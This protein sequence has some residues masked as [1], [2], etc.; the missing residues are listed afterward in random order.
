MAAIKNNR[1]I[2][3]AEMLPSGRV[4]LNEPLAPY[5][6]FRIGG[7]ADALVLPEN[8]NEL[9]TVLRYCADV[10]LSLF[11]LGRG[12]N[13]LIRDKGIRGVVV[14]LA[15]EFNR[16][17]VSGTAIL[18]GAGAQLAETARV[19]QQHG[20]GG[21]EFAHGI[22]GSIGGAT[23]MNAGAY[24]GE[25]KD[26]VTSVRVVDRQGVSQEMDRDAMAFGY[27]HSVLQGSDL[28]AIEVR[29][30]LQPA[31]LAA[32][33]AKMDNLAA[34]RRAKQPLDLPSAGS[35]FRRPPG[36]YAGTLIEQTGLKGVRIGDAQVSELHAGF[37]VNLGRATADDVMALI[38]IVQE[39]VREKFGVELETE[40]KVVGEA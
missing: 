8:G 13:L 10:G 31:D 32:V 4:R 20:L 5:T 28:I 22:P 37:I 7:P 18:A 27:R 6:T 38:K 14:K 3:L 19:A 25:M 21:M 23:V 15:G 2:Q 40:L 26:I 1:L 24:N 9:Q 29:L 30:R 34:R 36:Y 33:R 17:T 11:L 35:T 16:I 39:K 12:S